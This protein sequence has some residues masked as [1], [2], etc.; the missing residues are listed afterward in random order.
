MKDRL[1]NAKEIAIEDLGGNK[2]CHKL[3]SNYDS[4][5]QKSEREKK[6]DPSTIERSKY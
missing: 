1:I 3:R 4:Y 5:I 6:Q 2:Y